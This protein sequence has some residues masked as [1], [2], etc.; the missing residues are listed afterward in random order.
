VLT[1]FGLGR[2]A[3]QRGNETRLCDGISFRHPPRP[4]LANL[5]GAVTFVG[6]LQMWPA[7]LIQLGSIGPAPNA[8][9]NWGRPQHHVLPRAR[10]RARKRGD[11]AG[12]IGRTEQSPRQGNGA[13][14]R[15]G[16]GDRHRLLTYQTPSLQFRNGTLSGVPRPKGTKRE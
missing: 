8:R 11:I 4:A 10:Q 12:T 7:A 14:K 2:D 13:F 16:C 15:I 5:V 3:E 6:R 9:C 1:E